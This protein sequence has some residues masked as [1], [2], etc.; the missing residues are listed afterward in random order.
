MIQLVVALSVVGACAAQFDPAGARI[1]KDQR[2]NQGDGSFGTGFASEDGHVFREETTADGERIG[3]YSY[4]DNDGKNIVVKYTAGKDGFR[5]LE[6]DHVP[7]GSNGL[8][9]AAFNPD[10]AAKFSEEPAARAP[11]SQARPAFQTAPQP[12][13]QEAPTGRVARR[14]VV[15]RRRKSQSQNVRSQA[16]APAQQPQRQFNNFPARQPARQPAP[17]PQIRQPAPLPQARQPAPQ[18]QFA[19]PPQPQFTQQ[20]QQQFIQQPQ[21]Q[22]TQQPQQQFAP[23]PEQF[24]QAPQQFARAPQQFAQAQQ[25]FS[26][27]PQQFPQQPQQFSQPQQQFRPAPAPIPKTSP[28]LNS[29]PACADCDGFNPF[30]N[31]F[32]P[33]HLEVQHKPAPAAP[34]VP[35]APAAPSFR[36]TI[37]ASTFQAQR[38]PQQQQQFAPQQQFVPQQQFAP[39]QQFQTQQQFAPQQQFI[40]QPPP[41]Q[42]TIFNPQTQQFQFKQ[43]QRQAPQQIERNQFIKPPQVQALIQQF[44]QQGPSTPNRSF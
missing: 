43:L 3:Q 17:Q 42:Q 22:F 4:I 39:Q 29:I 9:S 23:A 25:Q 41:Q 10:I 18:Q 13:A 30:I 28:S 37:P 2:Y 6:G 33:S 16:P 11:T 12:E 24:R 35:A 27:A 38:F 31:P 40:P 8:E 21:Q 5:I 26:Q 44:Q 14:R 36:S 20:P 32:D 34:A 19:Q 15:A 7:K 1:L